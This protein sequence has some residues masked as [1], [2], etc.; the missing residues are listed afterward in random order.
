MQFTRKPENLELNKITQFR[1]R[2]QKENC[3]IEKDTWKQHAEKER[4]VKLCNHKPKWNWR[5]NL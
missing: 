1:D 3:V 2:K 4:N 5:R